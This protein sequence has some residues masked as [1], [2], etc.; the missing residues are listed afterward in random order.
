ML[1]RLDDIV[2]RSIIDDLKKR[3]ERSDSYRTKHYQ[4]D[5]ASLLSVTKIIKK[6]LFQ[7]YK[8]IKNIKAIVIKIF[9]NVNL[10]SHHTHLITENILIQTTYYKTLTSRP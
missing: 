7:L 5:I 10:Y 6:P 1:V 3:A 4:R 8:D 2:I 9:F